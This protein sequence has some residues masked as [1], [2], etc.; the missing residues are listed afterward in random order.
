MTMHLYPRR[1]ASSPR[2]IVSRGPWAF[3]WIF[4][5]A[6]PLRAEILTVFSDKGISGNDIFTWSGAGIALSTNA[7]SVGVPEGKY[8]ASSSGPSWNGWGV[9]YR[10]DADPFYTS[11]INLTRFQNGVMRFWLYSTTGDLTLGIERTSPPPSASDCTSGRK[12]CWNFASSWNTGCN[13][14]SCSNQW[15]LV[16]I[17][18]NAA[19]NL[20]NVFSPFQLTANS[21]GTFY[22]DKVQYFDT[23]AALPLFSVGI[24][25]TIGGASSG[26]LGWTVNAL[27]GWA[28]SDQ[29]IDLTIA[30]DE[31]S[32]GIQMYTD[33]RASD[34]NPRF[35]PS[36]SVGQPG[37]N[38]AGLVMA[39]TPNDKRLPLAWKI[40]PASAAPPA[41]G[42]PASTFGWFYFKDK[43]T[44]EILLEN[45]TP[46]QNAEPYIKVADNRGIHYGTG[47]LEFGAE[48]APYR[49]YV[50]ANFSGALPKIY[51]TNKII[52]EY[53]TP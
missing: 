16:Q 31:R 33:N 36:V 15:I 41:A 30:A 35:Q 11:G 44:P 7:T 45:T 17:S 52:L 24:K 40:Q 19:P 4:L 26:S 13:G 20:A 53:Y 3:L 46:F 37:S 8:T 39:S 48:D 21:A 14:Q 12:T 42:D 27:S 43:Q 18:L 49:I 29:Y 23:T 50:Q 9:M 51:S 38:P 47:D 2:R 1:K 6:L 5:F 25:N 28:R 22:V 32:W 34:A 10:A